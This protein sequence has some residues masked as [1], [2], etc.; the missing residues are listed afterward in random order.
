MNWKTKS[1]TT[2]SQCDLREL[3]L[4]P[5]TDPLFNSFY[6]P[7]D[8]PLHVE[9]LTLEL[10]ILKA[11]RSFPELEIYRTSRFG[12]IGL[13]AYE[14]GRVFL[15][16]AGNEW[17]IDLSPQYHDESLR[18]WSGARRLEGG[19]YA[20]SSVPRIGALIEKWLLENRLGKARPVTQA[21][22]AEQFTYE[23]DVDPKVEELVARHFSSGKGEP[24]TF[25]PVAEITL[26]S[27]PYRW[28]ELLLQIASLEKFNRAY[29]WDRQTEFEAKAKLYEAAFDVGRGLP[30]PRPIKLKKRILNPF[31][32]LCKE[33]C[34]V[35]DE[36]LSPA[37]RSAMDRHHA[38]SPDLP[39][40]DEEV[41]TLERYGHAL[42]YQW[43]VF[44]RLNFRSSADAVAKKCSAITAAIWPYLQAQAVK[45]IEAA[46][47]AQRNCNSANRF[48]DCRAACQN[49]SDEWSAAANAYYRCA[50]ALSFG[51]VW[52]DGGWPKR[53]KQVFEARQLA[54]CR[55]MPRVWPCQS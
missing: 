11:I 26:P 43:L 28:I 12:V 22:L 27:L 14:H 40:A 9:L 20:V 42:T 53:S 47:V 30:T 3:L 44:H 39:N 55:L 2:W 10:S 29:C 51:P 31:N 7:F 19:A 41:K 24:D 15:W 35:C 33:W 52:F 21:E 49:A 17:V 13:A 25:E 1:L 34:R 54:L 45:L 38:L 36:Q 50:D 32:L 18:P 46:E 6:L 23:A 48:A 37:A 4:P 5:A 16:R 8:S